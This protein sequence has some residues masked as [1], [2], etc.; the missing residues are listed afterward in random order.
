MSVKPT[1]FA[2]KKGGDSDNESAEAQTEQRRNSNLDNKGLD[3][4]LAAK[5]TRIANLKRQL[6]DTNNW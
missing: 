5:Y 4:L 1:A 3:D 6:Q 2:F